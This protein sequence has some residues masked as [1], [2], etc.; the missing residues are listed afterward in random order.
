MKNGNN[1]QN[2]RKHEANLFS[3]VLKN[4]FLLFLLLRSLKIFVL[5]R[6]FVFVSLQ[7]ALTCFVNF[8]NRNQEFWQSYR[9][10]PLE[11]PMVSFGKWVKSHFTVFNPFL[12]KLFVTFFTYF[13]I[14]SQ[15]L[16]LMICSVLPLFYRIFYSL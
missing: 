3:L 11:L 12:V 5:N 13:F 10:Q 7:K 4:K 14:K 16:I 15:I 2:F 9:A 8:V 1:F 6:L